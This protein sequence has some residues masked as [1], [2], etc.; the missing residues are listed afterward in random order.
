[1]SNVQAAQKTNGGIVM[2]LLKVLLILAALAGIGFSIATID[3]PNKNY[4][5]IAFEV[6]VIALLIPVAVGNL[7]R[8][9]GGR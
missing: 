2:P 4:Y 9:F 5:W 6:V 1:M 8:L 3:L 7:K